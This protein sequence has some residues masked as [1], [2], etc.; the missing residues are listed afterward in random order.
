VHGSQ[1]QTTTLRDWAA[2]SPADIVL[3]SIGGNDVGFADLAADCL[4][5]PCLWFAEDGLQQRAIDERHRLVQTYKAVLDAARERNP[6]AELW[7]ADYPA[8]A[9]GK[10]CGD[11]GYTPLI[12]RVNGYGV[13]RAEQVFLRDRFLASLNESVSW[14]AHD[15]GAHLLDLGGLSDGHELCSP[16]PYFN[17]ISPALQ[18][19]GPYL[20]SARTF[21]PNK[22]GYAHFAS[23]LWTLYGFAFGYGDTPPV[24]GGPRFTPQLSGSLRI[25]A[26]SSAIQDTASSDVL[27]R[28]GNQVHLKVSDAPPGNYRLVIRSLPTV[29][30]TIEV[31][32]SGNVETTFT[33]PTWLGPYA[34]WLTIEDLQGRPVLGVALQ[35]APPAGCPLD[36]TAP[37]T[38]GDALPDRCDTVADDG[39][40]ADV[41]ADGHSNRDDNCP[42]VANHQQ[43]DV[44]GDGLGDA[45]DPSQGATPPRDTA[46]T[47]PLRHVSPAR[48]RHRPTTAAPQMVVVAVAAARRPAVCPTPGAVPGTEAAR[49]RTP[50]TAW[51]TARTARA[52][53]SQAPAPVPGP[54][55]TTA[56][57][58][59]SRSTRSSGSDHP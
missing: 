17:G 6:K 53:R 30:G 35:L 3:L 31:P 57:R 27:F 44:D 16:D 14:A 28:P 58:V 7:V 46:R 33:V 24:G 37:D 51:L 12:G 22:T 15:A 38:D 47:S 43:G 49:R 9:S 2:T 18:G 41:D 39:P 54:S 8:P 48:R 1:S 45:C 40:L 20:V 10:V 55:S 36:P 26:D 21:H 11:V 23:A 29:L 52:R 42:L 25:G 5:G 59:A 4:M 32:A 34:H 13:D 50:A 56:A 19:D